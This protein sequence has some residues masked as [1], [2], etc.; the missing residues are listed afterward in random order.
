[1][2][3]VV[4]TNRAVNPNVASAATNWASFAG[5]GGT[6]AGARNAGVGMDGAAGFFRVTW[7]VATTAISGGLVYTQTG[8]AAATQYTHSMW[9]RCSKAQVVRLSAQYK[10]AAAADVGTATFGSNVTLVPNTWTRLSVTAT[11][12]ALVD[13]VA[14]TAA[15]TTGG[16]FWA[17]VDTF[18]GDALLIET[19][20]TL[21][22][23]FDGGYVD[24]LGV[25]YAWAAAA[26]ASTSTAT[27]Y[28]PLLTSSKRYGT[29]PCD[30]V[31]ITIA[32]LAPS[33]HTVTLW[34]TIDGRRAAVRGFRK[35]D[36]VGSDFVVDY[37]VPLGRSVLY[38]LEILSGMGRGGPTDTE[39]LTLSS[40]VCGWI[41]DPLEPESAVSVYS[42]AGPSGEPTLMDSALKALEY[43]A[44]ISI[45]AIM[46]S[47]DPVALLGQRMAQSGVAFHMFTDALS[48]GAKL[49]ALIQDSPLLLIRSM[50]DWGPSIP[51][52]C[53]V[54][55]GKPV[56]NPITTAW[57]GNLIEWKI[58]T[59][60]VAAPTMNIV[61]PVWTYA[62]VQALWTTYQQA[63]TALTGKSYLTVRK[64][65][66]GA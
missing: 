19:T 45:I 41:Q 7:S 27:A 28:T 46:G 15:A 4:R 38:E 8:L 56:E 59:P 21:K 35:V 51:A 61:V 58:D 36:I 30:R 48:Q 66:T 65:P 23:F 6:A 34:R 49:R 25:I 44:D 42:V 11:S 31:E 60:L 17:T 64:S 57:G 3:I 14:V 52:L 10:D 62:D 12:G 37:E 54:A 47:P 5:T 32:D 50:P 29:N 39:T 63:Q 24:G 16:S 55:P 13:R 18:D 53:Y 22:D 1:M 9:V 33:T 20:G 26:D 2:S 40:A 43:A